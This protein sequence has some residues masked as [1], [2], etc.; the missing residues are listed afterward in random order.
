MF[1]V[2]Q[3][4][5]DAVSAIMLNF[6]I[7]LVVFLLGL[8][9]IKYITRILEKI[10]QK[11][12]IDVGVSK[13][14]TSFI[15]VCLTILL[16]FFVL[17]KVG[18][19][20][21]SLLAILGSAGIA[22]SLALQN[23]LSNFASGIVLLI[24][25]PFKVGDYIINSNGNVEGTVKKI[26]LFYTVLKGPDLRKIT[27][28]NSIVANNPIF[29]VSASKYRRIE[30]LLTITYETNLLKAKEILSE[31]FDNNKKLYNK[32][33]FKNA[34]NVKDLKANGVL[35]R[36]IGFVENSLYL[37]TYFE[38]LEE[39]KIKFD[40]NGVELVHQNLMIEN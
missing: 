13:F 16:I 39:I 1:N 20:S 10:F 3:K 2:D 28:P 35:I 26:G 38:L 18:G 17:E 14:L 33:E 6:L 9:I 29:N 15:R 22:I 40:E 12:K 31:I 23:S 24:I 27:I 11:T 4:Y 19:S 37:Q 34:I 25:H 5:I 7:Y 32:E 8:Q 21:S 30:V 36:G